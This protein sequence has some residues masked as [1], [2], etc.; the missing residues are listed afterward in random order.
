MRVFYCINVEICNRVHI[1][2][3]NHMD[4][5]WWTV[6]VG[7]LIVVFAAEFWKA[8]AAVIR[9]PF[10]GGAQLADTR[11]RPGSETDRIFSRS[12]TIDGYALI[13]AMVMALV[14][15][16]ELEFSQDSRTILLNLI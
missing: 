1:A 12:S 14:K 5:R 9:S 7:G 15:W 13:L 11:L 6:V 2:T 10:G 16:W 3:R 8:L 4:I